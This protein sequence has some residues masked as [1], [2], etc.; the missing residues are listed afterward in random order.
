MT[1]PVEAVRPGTMQGYNVGSSNRINVLNG[2]DNY[3]LNGF[4]LNGYVLAGLL[5]MDEAELDAFLALVDAT[6]LNGFT[7][8]GRAERKA[9]R[10]E[11]KAR[12]EERRANREM[13]RSAKEERKERR[14]EAKTAR[15]EARAEKVQAKIEKIRSKVGQPGFMDKLSEL[16]GKAIEAFTGQP[17]DDLIETF[18]DVTGMDVPFVGEGRGGEDMDMGG[19]EMDER[20]YLIGKVPFEPWSGKWWGSKRVPIIQK[21]GVGAA[22]VLAVDAATGGN[23]VLKRVGLMNAKKRK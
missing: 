12:R 6:P 19:G 10:A 1:F 9:R 13:K 23:I 14:D 4:T 16:G 15:K 8:N 22:A 20:G 21:V 3:S 17:A 5:D 18:E 2:I 11:R 7:L